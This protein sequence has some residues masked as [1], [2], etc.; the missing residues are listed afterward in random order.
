M[1]SSRTRDGASGETKV[2]ASRNARRVSEI[3]KITHAIH[4][5]VVDY[6]FIRYDFSANIGRLAVKP[7]NESTSTSMIVFT[8]KRQSTPVTCGVLFGI[9]QDWKTYCD[10]LP[11]IWN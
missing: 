11:Y 10:L 6:L 9:T 2:R 8:R 7:R 3:T 1:L 4:R 5:R